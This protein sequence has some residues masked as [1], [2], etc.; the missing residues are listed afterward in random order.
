MDLRNLMNDP[1]AHRLNDSW[2][3]EDHYYTPTELRRKK[4]VWDSAIIEKAI[5]SFKTNRRENYVDSNDS[6]PYGDAQFIKVREF[7]GH[8]QESTLDEKGNDDNYILAQFI[9]IMGERLSSQNKQSS[10]GAVENAEGLIL[11]KTKITQEKGLGD[12]YKEV[13]FRRIKGRW[14]GRGLY[15][16]LSEIQGMKNTEINQVMMAMRLEALIIFQTQDPTVASNI[17]KDLANGDI[18]KFKAGVQG[19]QRVDTRIHGNATNNMLSQEIDKLANELAN[20]YEVT[21]GATMPSGTPFSLTALLNQNANKLFDFIREDFGLFIQEI[22]EDWVMPELRKSLSLKH[23]LEITDQDEIEMLREWWARSQVWE[24]IKTLML[25]G[26]MPTLGQIDAVQQYLLARISAKDS[27]FLEYPKD[28]YKDVQT[29]VQ[30]VIT[31]EQEDPSTLQSLQTIL[32]AVAQNPA[33][34]DNPVFQSILDRLGFSK[35]DF[36]V[37]TPTVPP[38]MAPQA[39]TGAPASPVGVPATA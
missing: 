3:I 31:G 7:Y 34:L 13:H 24:S 36:S 4:G 20:S 35:Y 8:V 25:S 22:I 28:Y 10:G 15:E 19:L 5:Q 21:T 14:I 23:I 39:P 12:I 9:L 37:K 6:M 29:K 32:Q 38:Q 16:E 18:L 27:F 30:V 2:V 17:L 33:M 1:A 11:F 26:K